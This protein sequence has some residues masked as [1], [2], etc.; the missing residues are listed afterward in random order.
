[1]TKAT[2]R[3]D[4]RVEIV[5]TDAGGTVTTTVFRLN[6]EILSGLLVAQLN[7]A[8]KRVE[9]FETIKADGE[10]EFWS[11]G[12]DERAGAAEFIAAAAEAAA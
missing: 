4:G 11:A 9:R 3:T 5:T 2:Y 6:S 1:M 10:R 8:F 7:D 12:R